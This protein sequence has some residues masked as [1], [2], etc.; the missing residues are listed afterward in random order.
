MNFDLS[1]RISRNKYRWIMWSIMAF[2]FLVSFFH[3]YSL[4]VVVD[5]IGA[6]LDLTGTQIGNLASMYFY[7]YALL[8]IPAGIMADTVG[9]RKLTAGGMLIAGAGAILFALSGS[10][11]GVYLGRLLV[12]AGVAG[13][14]ICIMR[15]QAVWFRPEKF[16]T[17]IGYSTLIG[18][19]GGILATTPFALLVLALGWRS[20]FALIAGVSLLLGIILWWIVRDRPEELGYESVNFEEPE[21][22]KG[23]FKL[24]FLHVIKQPNTWF[25]FLALVGVLGIVMSF[26]ST[27]GVQYLM[28]TYGFSRDAAANYVLIFTLGVIVGSPV[29]GKAADKIGRRKPLIQLGAAVYA[30]VWGLKVIGYGSNPPEVLLPFIYFTAG[31]F[32]I[33]LMLSHASVKESNPT[34]FT[35]TALSIINTAP[36][37]GT[38]VMNF[39]TGGILDYTWTGIMD[40]GARFYELSS[41]HYAF[42]AY[43]VFTLVSFVATFFIKDTRV[44]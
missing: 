40:N 44:K 22:K 13:I 16:A 37:V 42:L 26:S 28:Q 39:M 41:Y 33:F 18:N 23:D 10:L 25:C 31:F 30:L 43:F 11:P 7:I 32:G 24:G 19:S 6:E 4:V 1:K 34:R 14:L 20:S 17:L 9:A 3:R 36:F 5:T 15:V 38:V 8:Q 35:G 29:M 2:A 12:S 27:W 21:K